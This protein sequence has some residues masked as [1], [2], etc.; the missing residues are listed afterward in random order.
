MKGSENILAAFHDIIP[1]HPVS[2]L[3]A[4]PGYFALLILVLAALFPIGLYLYRHH[5]RNLYR[6]DALAE[7]SALGSVTAPD[8]Q[9]LAGLQ[10]LK[11]AAIVA[12]GRKQT[13]ALTGSDWWRFLG[14]KSGQ[15]LDAGLQSY[16][17]A[18]HLGNAKPDSDRNRQVFAYVRR[19]IKKHRGVK[20]D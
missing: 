11:R 12:Y 13:A 17:E 5:M 9:L 1:P 15:M 4:S 18:V 10:L 2:M 7:L 6:K 8:E 14:G 16:C 19:W 20:I 3:P